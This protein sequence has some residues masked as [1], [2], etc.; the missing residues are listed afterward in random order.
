MVAAKKSSGNALLTG[1][2]SEFLITKFAIS[3]NTVGRFNLELNI[4]K[5]AGMYTDERNLRV[6]L[7]IDEAWYDKAQKAPTCKEKVQHAF[8][9]LPV[10]FILQSSGDKGGSWVASVRTDLN[11]W[12][13]KTQYWYISLDDCSLEESYHSIKDVP[14][15]SYEYTILNGRRSNAFSRSESHF[16][17]DEV[18]TIRLHVI[19]LAFSSLLLIWCA[20]KI[21]R[22]ITSSPG[23]I[24]IAL[25]IISSALICDILSNV[26]EL[27]HNMVY[28][29][30]GVGSYTFDAFSSHFEAQ[31][32]AM[33]AIV[34]LLVGSGWTLP[35]DVVVA[36]AGNNMAMLGTGNTVQKMVEGLRNPGVALQQIKS[37]NPA[38]ILVTTTFVSHAILAQWGRT[39]DDDF[40][41]YH[42][43]E[44]LPGTC[45]MVYR[46]MLGI[47]FL[48]GVAS[49][50]NSGRCPRAL[51]PFLTKFMLVGI[52][53]FIS[54]PFVTTFVS[55][56]MPYILKHRSLLIGSAMTQASSLASLVWLFTADS[57]ASAY[58]RLSKVRES[59]TS[60]SNV[61]ASSSNSERKA[62]SSFWK[63]G[64]T[65]IR[66]D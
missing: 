50:R 57:D 42:S 45:L 44:H 52:S 34:L 66:L 19:Q 39:Y 49:V 29:K 41:C 47:P 11:S 17:A 53:W 32:D 63:F 18:G 60:L 20:F 58:H 16:S 15:M 54:L 7:F 3:P 62:P 8:K 4:P 61:V 27:I 13:D 51:K 26:S 33:I 30:N 9:S 5:T 6:H 10:T 1:T 46:L 48:I 25:L 37:G 12:S 59:N 24:H 21:V 65:K 31:C 40:D 14:K 28:S 36:N 23:H 55:T 22:T 43:L 64:K 35:S 2:N 56:S 38:S